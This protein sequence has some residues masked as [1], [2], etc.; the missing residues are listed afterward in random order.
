MPLYCTC[1]RSDCSFCQR[2]EKEV[3]KPVLASG[4]YD[5]VADSGDRA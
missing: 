4:H 2:F 3:L 1:R 5:D